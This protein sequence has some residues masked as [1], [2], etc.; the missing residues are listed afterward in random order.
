MPRDALPEVDAIG[1]L[2][3]RAAERI[4]W[5]GTWC[6]YALARDKNSKHVEPGS[7]NA[8]SWCMMG[9]IKAERP[10]PA[11]RVTA[12]LRLQALVEARGGDS[13]FRF[14]D[15]RGQAAVVGLLEEAARD[16]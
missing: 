13:V 3:L 11:A 4:R 2:L 10:S 9:A 7:R 12:H 5:P 8:V 1:A 16:V 14:N 6:Q 15:S